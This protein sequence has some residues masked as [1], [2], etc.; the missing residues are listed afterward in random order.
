MAKTTTAPDAEAKEGKDAPAKGGKGG[1]KKLVMAVALVVLV[2][3]WFFLMGPGSG[4]AAEKPKPKPG[5]VLEMEP[6]TMNL[7]DGRLL[8]VGIALQPTYD[9]AYGMSGAK[10]L[11]ETIAFL[12]EHTY[13]QLAAPGAR[14]VAK[15]ELTKR[16]IKRYEKKVMEVYFTEFVMQ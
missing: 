13:E 14:Q 9:G 1:K 12:G 6:I 7:A 10:A 8:K 16:I 11:D 15:G 3:G 4:D 5:E 2:A